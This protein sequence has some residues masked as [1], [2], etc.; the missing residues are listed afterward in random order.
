MRS[1]PRCF[2][3]VTLVFMRPPECFTPLAREGKAPRIL[4]RTSRR[5]VPVRLLSSLLLSARPVFA[6]SLRWGQAGIPPGWSISLVCVDSS[7]GSVLRYA[8][9]SSGA[10]FRL[11]ARPVQLPGR[12]GILP[13]SIVAGVLCVIVTLAARDVTQF[14]A[15]MS[16]F[17]I[18]AYIQ[19]SVHSWRCGSVTR[20]SQGASCRL[21]R[22]IFS[23]RHDG[24]N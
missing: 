23:R 18:V 8:I 4:G 12:A 10:P 7:H 16:P 15:L 22:P 20:L 9:S 3:L 6:T 1:S 19:H 2:R 21:Q 14:S 17:M 11:G 13:E 5:G 24:G